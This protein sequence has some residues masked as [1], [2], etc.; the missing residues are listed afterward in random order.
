VRRV[1]VHSETLARAIQ[2]RYKAPVRSHVRMCSRD[3]LDEAM[4]RVGALGSTASISLRDERV[5]TVVHAADE[6]EHVRS[7]VE[8]IK[9][10]RSP[11][12]STR[13]M[14]SPCGMPGG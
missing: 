8:E 6:L 3:T 9:P 10:D 7:V 13:G 12:V 2:M 1:A 11:G 5:L 14:L 4:R